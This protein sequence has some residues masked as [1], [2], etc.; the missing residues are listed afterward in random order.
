[1]VRFVGLARLS[2]LLICFILTDP[3]VH[4]T[5]GGFDDAQGKSGGATPAGENADAAAE[6]GAT[7]SL[8]AS[9]GGGGNCLAKAVTA[10]EGPA[11]D[12][13]VEVS[14]PLTV[15][16]GAASQAAEE[17]DGPDGSQP[18][19]GFTV[20]DDTGSG[21]DTAEGEDD[22]LSVPKVEVV[23]FAEQCAQIWDAMHQ[24]RIWRP[25]IFICIW[26]LVPGN[27]DAFNSF[28]QGCASK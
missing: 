3:K 21:N 10:G 2:T 25:M 14:S 23:G 11:A 5:P 26:A 17:V 8:L 22:G 4:R 19:V 20:G 28:T 18:A 12:D 9:A 1:M 24:D 15:V 13:S 7:A 6:G 27:G 16:D